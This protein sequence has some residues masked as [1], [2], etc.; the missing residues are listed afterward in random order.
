MKLSSSDII[1]KFTESNDAEFNKNMT[2]ENYNEVLNESSAGEEALSGK[3]MKQKHNVNVS[4]NHVLEKELENISKESVAT[5]Q[6]K[7]EVTQPVIGIALGG[8]G[9][10][11][12]AHIGILKVLE[13]NNIIPTKYAGTSMGAIVGA[14]YCSGYQLNHMAKLAKKL[15]AFQFLDVNITGRGLLNGRGVERILKKFISPTTKME[16]LKYEFACNA[17]NLLTGHEVVFK[18]GLVLKNIRASFSVPGIFA[19]T[20]VND[21]LC[22]DGGLINNV[23]SDI[24]KSM[25]ADIIIAVDVVNAYPKEPKIKSVR[26]IIYYSSVIGQVELTK[27]KISYADV[28]IKPQLENYKQFVFNKTTAE[29]IIKLGEQAA[30]NALPD[31]LKSIIN[32]QKNN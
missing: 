29:E 6:H 16:D 24:V 22:I 28:T 25:G 1:K 8:G 5:T 7:R 2:N 18:S 17:V 27:H 3:D 10:F 14:F 30:K 21:A 9:A 13:E 4:S 12:L 20:E 23:P 15:Q 31:I 19:P 26:D 32:Y 11:G